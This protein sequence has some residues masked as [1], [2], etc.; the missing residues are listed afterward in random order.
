MRLS[1]AVDHQTTSEETQNEQ[2]ATNIYWIGVRLDPD[3]R[4]CRMRNL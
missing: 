2:S 4:G 1:D 3:V